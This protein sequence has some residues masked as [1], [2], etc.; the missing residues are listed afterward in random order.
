MAHPVDRPNAVLCSKGTVEDSEMLVP[1]SR[2]TLD[3]LLFV[4]V[5]D[6]QVEPVVFQEVLNVKRGLSSPG[7]KEFPRLYER[8]VLAL[9]GLIARVDELKAQGRL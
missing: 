1:Q 2:R 8:Y 7:K 6:I 5:G 4:D 3:R 9:Q